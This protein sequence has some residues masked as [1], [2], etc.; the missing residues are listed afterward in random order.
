MG[1]EGEAMGWMSGEGCYAVDGQGRE[2][3]GV[4]E[5]RGKLWGGRVGR[6]TM[7]WMGGQGRYAV[8]GQGREREA[9]GWKG[10]EGRYGVERGREKLW[11]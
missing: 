8:D 6:D 3:N 2:S 4:D 9:M 11:G 1:R 7:G 10:G 5:G